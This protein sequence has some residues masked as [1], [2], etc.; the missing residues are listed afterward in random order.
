[1]QDRLV[2][3][4]VLFYDLRQRLKLPAIRGLSDF[5]GLQTLLEGAHLEYRVITCDFLDF[6]N[7]VALEMD[8]DQDF[9]EIND[10]GQLQED[11]IENMDENQDFL[12]TNYPDRFRKDL[13][14]DVTIP[15]YVFPW[16]DSGFNEVFIHPNQVKHSLAN[17]GLSFDVN[18]IVDV[19]K[20]LF[21]ALNSPKLLTNFQAI[22]EQS[23]LTQYGN[24]ALDWTNQASVIAEVKPENFRAFMHRF[25][26]EVIGG[27]DEHQLRY[28][29]CN[30][31]AFDTIPH[32]IGQAL[33]SGKKEEALVLAKQ[34]SEIPG[35]IQV[36]K[37]YPANAP[38]YFEFIMV[39]AVSRPLDGFDD[40]FFD[41]QRAGNINV[42]LLYN[43]FEGYKKDSPWAFLKNKF[44]LQSPSDGDTWSPED[45]T[46]CKTLTAKHTRNLLFHGDL[47]T[48]VF[49]PLGEDTLDLV[50]A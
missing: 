8:E 14:Q 36:V 47:I 15:E 16:F 44:S 13:F 31:L 20:A 18:S 21:E 28:F 39:Y 40:L 10:L 17:I 33:E 3:G 26:L 46:E 7:P 25:W 19:I 2:Y 34:I 4:G 24:Q 48:S 1:M 32:I 5:V 22:A 6:L 30:M 29:L 23:F 9:F 12:G 43:C 45:S 41:I 35:V 37:S 27:N 50:W 49:F 38:N 11:E 42:Q